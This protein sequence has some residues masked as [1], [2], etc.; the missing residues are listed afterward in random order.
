MQS[1]PATASRTG[2]YSPAGG[3]EGEPPAARGA[4]TTELAKETQNPVAG[5]ISY[6]D[7]APDFGPDWQLRFQLQLLF[8]R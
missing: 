4:S 2:R 5:L 1:V 7:A 8:P 3:E 6:Y